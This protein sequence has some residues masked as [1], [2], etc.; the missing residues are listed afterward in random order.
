MDESRQPVLSDEQWAMVAKRLRLSPRE[1]EVTRGIFDG[2]K[3]AVVA[4]ELKISPHTLHTHWRRVKHKL[5]IA[6]RIEAIHRIYAVIHGTTNEHGWTQIEKEVRSQRSEVSKDRSEG[7]VE[8]SGA[9]VS[10]NGAGVERNGAAVER[11]GAPVEPNRAIVKVTG[12][13]GTLNGADVE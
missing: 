5:Q 6:D 3:L 12:A 8:R 2:R 7:S 9:A 13:T 1:M 11:P 4:L 10:G